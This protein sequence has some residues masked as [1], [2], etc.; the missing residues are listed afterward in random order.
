VKPSLLDVLAEPMTGAPLSLC[1][2]D[3]AADDGDVLEGELRAP[4]GSRYAIRRGIPRFVPSDTY[5]SSFGIQWQRFAPV[6]LD[7]RTGRSWSEERFD[8]EVPW[9]RCLSGKWIVDAGCGAGRF[10]EIAARRG[11]NVVAVDLSEAVDAVRD[12]LGHLPNVHPV[13]AD[14]AALPV[15]PDTVAGAYSLGVLQHTPD[16]PSACRALLSALPVGAP[17]SV[18]VYARR[19]WTRAYAKYLVRPLTR[20]LSPSRL[21][22]LIESAMPALFPVTTRLFSL[23]GA[24]RVFRFLI[25]VANYVERDYPDPLLRY[26]EAVLDTFDM[27]SPTHDHPVTVAEVVAGLHGLA[28]RI[29]VHS[30]IPVS[31]TVQR[32]DP[33]SGTTR[34][35]PGRG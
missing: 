14:L 34:A 13:Q 32:T 24:G 5:S 3:K 4:D 15:R 1:R 27:L 20:R 30:Q 16:P 6:Q 10:A 17:L 26:E 7:S 33:N 31:L 2:V 22:A 19:P 18:T 8:R 35:A 9:G 28:G 21:L 12:V 23:P 11:A 29:E 25:P